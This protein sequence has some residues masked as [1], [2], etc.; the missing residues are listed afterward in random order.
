M[1]D[2]CTEELCKRQHRKGKS[3]H[4]QKADAVSLFHTLKLSCTDIL[5]GVGRN[6][7]TERIIRLLYQL[8][9]T[10]GCRKRR[11]YYGTEGIH[12]AL[13]RHA[14]DRDQGALE[15]KR[16]THAD[17][18]PDNATVHMAVF[19]LNLKER[20]LKQCK[21]K[22][23]QTGDHLRNDRCDS[24]TRNTPVKDADKHQIKHDIHN[25]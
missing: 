19:L 17:T 7:H 10:A 11:N 25:T 22:A 12:N 24:G 23:S 14:R 20:I 8:L 16:R 1:H 9:D 18:L 2:L 13:Q 5:S 6:R 21:N 3:C 15:R 4:H